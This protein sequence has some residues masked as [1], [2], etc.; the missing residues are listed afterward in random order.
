MSITFGSKRVSQ[1][2]IERLRGA[3]CATLWSILGYAYHM[4]NI[5]PLF[6]D[7][8]I[9]GPALT[10]KY[11]EIRSDA[12]QDQME[13]EYERFGNPMHRL[14]ETIKPGDVIVGAALGHVDA[15]IFGDCLA[16][17]F[18]AK[19][20]VALVSDGSVRDSSGIRA[21][22]IPVFTVGPATP[23]SSRGGGVFPVEENVTVECDGVR[24]RVGDIIVG[25]GDGIVVLPREWGEEVAKKA[26]AKE[27]LEALSRKL[28]MEGKPLS[29]CYPY[30]KKEYVT[31]YGLKDYWN[32]LYPHDKID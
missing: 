30:L 3:S 15:G 9:V 6:G 5:K 16:A 20:A 26:E 7:C 28:L 24:V 13:R 4:R 32:L 21:M 2:T 25:D 17:G 14:A 19:G 8:K 23:L 27:K 22:D 10:I 1:E 18:K 29:E 11:S 31:H 12:T